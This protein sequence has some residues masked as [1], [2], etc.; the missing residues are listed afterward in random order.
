M[1][2][3]N[4]STLG[5]PLANYACPEPAVHAN[6]SACN[7]LALMIA[8]ANAQQRPH[9][10]N[11]LLSAWPAPATHTERAAQSLRMQGL[12]ATTKPGCTEGEQSDDSAETVVRRRKCSTSAASG[13]GAPR[14]GK[15]KGR[16]CQWSAEEHKRF[17]DG[18]NRFGPKDL[19]NPEPGARISVGLG[20]GVA[21][22]IA[23]V[24]GT[25]TVSQV[26]SHAQV[27]RLVHACC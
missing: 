7:N 26:R 5:L 22:V 21:E 27:Q 23:V 1:S 19:G 3:S 2:L 16:R 15:Q 12:C 9:Q 13:S 25:R 11:N 24:V 4:T 20:P 6:A 8:A 18:L 14:A 10:Q 17:L